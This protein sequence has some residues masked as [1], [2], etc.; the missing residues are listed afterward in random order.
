M[1]FEEGKGAI[2]QM[3]PQKKH[4][5]TPTLEIDVPQGYTVQVTRRKTNTS[6]TILVTVNKDHEVVL[7]TE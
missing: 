6:R 5:T 3:P 1:S 7:R 2:R 4:G